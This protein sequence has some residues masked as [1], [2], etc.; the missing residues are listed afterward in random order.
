VVNDRG[1][2]RIAFHAWKKRDVTSP[3][4]VRVAWTGRL[5]WR[6]T[7]GVPYLAPRRPAQPGAV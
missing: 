3:D 2:H 7:T 4:R 6:R 1:T 5:L